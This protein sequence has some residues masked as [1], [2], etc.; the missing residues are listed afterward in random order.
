MTMDMVGVAGYVRATPLARRQSM[1]KNIAVGC[2][3]TLGVVIGCGGG[4]STGS[5]AD[6][7]ELVAST[8]GALDSNS[9][10]IRV[11]SFPNVCAVLN[12]H[13]ETANSTEIEIKMT[14]GAG[15]STLPPGSYAATADDT[16]AGASVEF[17]MWDASCN[18]T[19]KLTSTSGTVKLSSSLGVAGQIAEGS[20]DLAFSDGAHRSGTFSA[21]FCNTA[22]QGGSGVCTGGT[23]TN[24]NGGA[25]GNTSGTGGIPVGPGGDSAG[26]GGAPA[27]PPS[28]VGSIGCPG[29]PS[30]AT[31]GGLCPTGYVCCFQKSPPGQH[32]APTAAGCA[33]PQ[34]PYACDGDEDC[35]GARCCGD[36]VNGSA[37]MASCSSTSVPVHC[38]GRTNC[39]PSE[40]C[41]LGAA[42]SCGA[43]GTCTGARVCSA[44][45]D[46]NVGESCD[47][48]AIVQS[49]K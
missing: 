34:I 1:N 48:G 20:Y 8:W 9:W 4:G 17:K 7:Q 25:G 35:P 18:S 49:C 10:L 6:K 3:V 23:P 41:C 21:P 29:D 33:S 27:G 43:A 46:C 16:I 28:K 11:A 26:T 14:A 45:T 12:Q 44:T 24:G 22:T 42:L 19:V 37:C 36:P 30:T 32:C 47:T 2:F 15:Q 38:L 39:G 13:S 40:D 31:T 5:A